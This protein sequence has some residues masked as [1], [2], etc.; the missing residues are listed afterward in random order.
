MVDFTGG[1]WRSL[2]DGSEV[3]T[4]LDTELGHIAYG[5]ANGSDCYIHDVEDDYSLLHTL[6]DASDRCKTTTYNPTG[7]EFVISGRDGDVHIYDTEDDYN[8]IETLTGH[9]GGVEAEIYFDSVADRMMVVPVDDDVHIYDTDEYILESEFTQAG[10]DQ[11]G[12]AGWSPDDTYLAYSGPGDDGTVHVHD[13]GDYSHITTLDE[14]GTVQGALEWGPNGDY[15][16]YGDQESDV[17]IHNVGEWDLEE[18]LT[19][20]DGSIS[21]ALGWSHDG[22]YLAVGD[23]DAEV[24]VWDTSNWSV[25][26]TLTDASGDIQ[27]DLDFK[28]DDEYM[29]YGTDA[30]DVHIH[31]VGGWNEVETLTEASRARGGPEWSP[32]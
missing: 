19:D 1:T 32:E 12:S 14:G 20:L 17:Y 24:V 23:R 8:L 22:Q 30:G 11:L 29:A 16:A 9:S 10:S 21:N 5:D 28:P 18:T 13:G 6:T 25:E 27:G 4:L 2:V 31:D 26:T 3:I 15:I 7:L